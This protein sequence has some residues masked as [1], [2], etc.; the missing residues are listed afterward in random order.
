MTVA[1]GLTLRAG[2][3]AS[4]AVVLVGG[5]LFLARYGGSPINYAVFRGEPRQ[6]RNVAEII[7][8]ASAWSSRGIIQLGLL[9]LLA[10]PVIRVALA[11]F[12]FIMLRD[13]TYVLIAAIVLGLLAVGLASGAA[14]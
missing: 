12:N 13:T 10:T 11:L 8:S 5:V 2:V 1:I 9:I 3:V 6:L 14:P 4:C 7:A